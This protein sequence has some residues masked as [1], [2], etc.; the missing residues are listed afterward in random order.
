MNDVQERLVR[1]DGL[2]VHVREVGEGPPILLLNGVAADTGMWAR[3]EA[4]LPGFRLISFDAPG[5][6]RSPAPLV[7]VSI[8]RLA[9]LAALVLNTIGVSG[10]LGTT[11]LR[12]YRLVLNPAAELA[13]L[14]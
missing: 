12:Q 8:R 14:V 11:L 4:A 3:L 9:R 2:S 1:L 13:Y 10:A 7:P 5:S 6:G